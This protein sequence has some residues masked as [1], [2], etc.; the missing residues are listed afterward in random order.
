MNF[1]LEKSNLKNLQFIEF[2]TLKF[3]HHEF[4]ISPSGLLSKLNIHCKIERSKEHCI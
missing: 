2:I 1:G 4:T 3:I